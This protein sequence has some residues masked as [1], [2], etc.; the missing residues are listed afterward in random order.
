MRPCLKPSVAALLMLCA[1]TARSAEAALRPHSAM[2]KDMS[3]LLLVRAQLQNFADLAERHLGAAGQV[4]QDVVTVQRHALH[5]RG[6]QHRG[7]LGAPS[8]EM[9]QEKVYA[10]GATRAP[11]SSVPSQSKAT[12]PALCE[13]RSMRRTTS[14]LASLTTTSTGLALCGSCTKPSMSPSAPSVPWNRP[15]ALHDRS[16]RGLQ[17]LA[18]VHGLAELRRPKSAS[19][20]T[21]AAVSKAASWLRNSPLCSGCMGSWFCI[22]VSISVRKVSCELCA[23]PAS[24][25]T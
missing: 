23:A 14:P 11:F 13:P 20:S 15:S 17:R 6:G 2:R 24:R 22:C 19:P 1:V 3:S 8:T 12:R 7:G 5:G 4:Q 18:R 10:P 21:P 9:L 16:G 25:A